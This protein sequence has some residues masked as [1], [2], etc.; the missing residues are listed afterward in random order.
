[1]DSQQIRNRL[2]RLIKEKALFCQP[3]TLSSGKKSSYYVDGKQVTLSG[4]GAWLV[5][6]AVLDVIKNDAIEAIGGPMIGAD[7]IVGA[8]VCL[9]HLHQSPLRGFIVRREPKKHGMQQYIEGP[10]LEKGTRVAIIDDVITT[11]ESVLRAA[12]AAQ[13]LGCKVVKVIVLVDRLEGAGERLKQHG[14]SFAPI[15]TRDDLGVS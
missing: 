6:K 4:E 1:M 7:P 8:L 9:S 14:L 11:G 2:L 5:A 12:Q 13:E 3:I 15:F 10:P